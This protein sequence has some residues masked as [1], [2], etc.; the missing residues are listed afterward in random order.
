[1][2]KIYTN[3]I[4]EID[5]DFALSASIIRWRKKGE[6][7]WRGTPFQVGDCHHDPDTAVEKIEYWLK[8]GA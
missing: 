5:A 7:V 3:E 2:R 8:N 6:G 1:M 4:I